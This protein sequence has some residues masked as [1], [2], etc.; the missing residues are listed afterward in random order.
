MRMINNKV[1]MFTE[2]Q[3]KIGEAMIKIIKGATV[4]FRELREVFGVVAKFYKG[5]KK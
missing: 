2:E 3:K 1:K 4:T 5:G